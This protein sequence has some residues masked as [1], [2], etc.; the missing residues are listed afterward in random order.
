MIGVRSDGAR[1]EVSTQVRPPTPR[2]ASA[3]ACLSL[4][5]F[6]SRG[7]HVVVHRVMHMVHMVMVVVVMMMVV[8]VVMHFGF[9]RSGGG[10]LRDGCSSQADRQSGGGED[11]LDHGESSCPITGPQRASFP[12]AP[13]ARWTQHQPALP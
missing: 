5:G 2:R 7:V 4:W 12:H 9:C 8:M 13:R 6:R 1:A 11:G 3:D 10:L